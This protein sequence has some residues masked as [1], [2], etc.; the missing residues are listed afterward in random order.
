MNK[1]TLKNF[2]SEFYQACEIAEIYPRP[3]LELRHESWHVPEIFSILE[4]AQIGFCIF[5]IRNKPSPLRITSSLVY[6]R[7]HGPEN[8]PYKG[9]YGKQMLYPWNERIC[10]WHQKGLDCFVYFDNTMFDEAV[11]DALILK[12]LTDETLSPLSAT[13]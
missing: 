10:E 9:T 8:V 12:K 11:P 2:I 4:K 6:I 3:T 5:D 13:G 1:R 7:L